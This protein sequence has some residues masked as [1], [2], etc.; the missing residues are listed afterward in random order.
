MNGNKHMNISKRICIYKI[1]RNKRKLLNYEEK[2]KRTT[3]HT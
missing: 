1:W 2:K 3:D